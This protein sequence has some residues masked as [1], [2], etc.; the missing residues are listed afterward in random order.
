MACLKC[1]EP[2]YAS[3]MC[4]AHFSQ[5][6]EKKVSKTIKRFSLFGKG[7]VVGVAASG[8]KDSTACLHILKKLGYDVTALTV[9]AQIGS[10]TEENL[11]AL[12][13][14][15]ESI[16]VPLH[17][18]SF[19]GE[20]GYSLNEVT[21]V[22]KS[23]GNSTSSCLVCGVLRRYLL[24]KL[25]KELGL[26][27][28][29]TGHTMDDEVQAFL[30]NIFRNDARLALRQGPVTG[31]SDASGFVKRVKPLYLCTEAETTAYSKLCG[32]HVK[33][34]RCP[35]SVDAYRRQFRDFLDGFEKR[36]PSVKHNI[37]S[38]YLDNVLPLK[39]P[40]A[41]PGKC[42]KCGEPASDSLCKRCEILSMLG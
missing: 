26:D 2:V 13:S 30:M 10:Y 35:C 39:P 36:H 1:P 28:V 25:A 6:F 27:V 29:A 34:E 7:D 42:V 20:F 37:M 12:R 40:V 18:I 5:Y 38:F 41:S 14:F 11:V 8:G 17:E 22:L 31:D 33:Y 16:A 9:D 21:S 32:F 23:K 15:C 19:K 4:A 3:G 24:N